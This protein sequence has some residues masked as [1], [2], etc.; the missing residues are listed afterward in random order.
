[1][2]KF[3]WFICGFIAAYLIMAI[4]KLDIIGNIY[5]MFKEW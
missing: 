1:M 3:D 5:R 4:V 2:N